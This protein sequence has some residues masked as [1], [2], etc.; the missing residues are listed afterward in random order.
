MSAPYPFT[1][2]PSTNTGPKPVQYPRKGPSAQSSLVSNANMASNAPRSQQRGVYAQAPS[3]S[4]STVNLLPPSARGPP[5]SVQAAFARAPQ[6]P[7]L[8]SMPSSSDLVRVVVF[9][10]LLFVVMLITPPVTFCF[11]ARLTLFCR[12]SCYW[13]D[14]IYATICVE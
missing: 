12:S 6:Q 1:S 13:E 3:N 10:A 5:S 9:C 11:V 2:N 4:P 8:R 14:S 7:G